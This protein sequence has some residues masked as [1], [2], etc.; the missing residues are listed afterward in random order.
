MLTLSL[1]LSLPRFSN[2]WDSSCLFRHTNLFPCIT[3]RR[4]KTVAPHTHWRMALVS[5]RGVSQM[6]RGSDCVRWHSGTHTHKYSSGLPEGS[7]W[8]CVC[9]PPHGLENLLHDS[10]SWVDHEINSPQITV[11]LRCRG[12][13]WWMSVGLVRPQ[14]V[15]FVIT[16]FWRVLMSAPFVHSQCTSVDL[17]ENEAMHSL[18]KIQTHTDY[19]LPWRHF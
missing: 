11:D 3:Q 2:G 7:V 13:R 4:R 18:I 5:L 9:R 15:P 16:S 6:A 14:G 10:Q 19:I 12:L 8:V 17:T 1:S